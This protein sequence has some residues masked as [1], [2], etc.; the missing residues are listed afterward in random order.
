MNPYEQFERLRTP[1]TIIAN[2]ID[3]DFN[4]ILEVGCQ[5]AENIMAVE[6]KYP[7][8]KIVGIDTDKE[9]INEAQDYVKAELIYGNATKL[10]FKDKS[11]DVVFTN[12][13]FC[14]LKE[15]DVEPALREI[16]RVA[17]KQMIFIELMSDKLVGAVPGG[18]MGLNWNKQFPESFI[19]KITE[20]EWE[21][22]PWKSHGY[23]IKVKL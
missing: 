1:K 10:P 21:V 22:E 16:K 4:N 3:V 7:D 23:L 17:K 20:K 14:M 6:M 9:T 2:E 13:L 19:R 18:R 8:K 15:E 11:F 12:A 5:W